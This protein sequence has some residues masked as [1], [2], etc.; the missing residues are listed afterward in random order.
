M[1]VQV[2]SPDT[3]PCA[4]PGA[5]EDVHAKRAAHSA[6]EQQG[7][8]FCPDIAVEV[9]GE[10][11]DRVRRYRDRPQP[12]LRLRGPVITVPSRS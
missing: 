3:A 12:G 11:P 10:A 8:G 1:E 7:I 4:I 9:F 6:S 2:S 5:L